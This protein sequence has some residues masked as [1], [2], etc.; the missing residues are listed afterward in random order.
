MSIKFPMN[1]RTRLSFNI[2]GIL[3]LSVF[4]KNES[5]FE[6]FVRII[7]KFDSGFGAEL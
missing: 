1:F 7:S 5:F 4:K 2:S 3:Y 6:D